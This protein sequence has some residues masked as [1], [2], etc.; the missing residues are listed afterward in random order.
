MNKMQKKGR[1]IRPGEVKSVSIEKQMEMVRQ[2]FEERFREKE[3]YDRQTADDRHLRLL[4]DM[5]VAADNH[6]IIDLGTGSGYLAFALARKYPDCTV[7]GLDTVTDTLRRNTQQARRCGLNNLK[8]IAGDGQRMPFADGSA[9][10]IIT[11][12]ALHHFADISGCFQEAHRVLKPGGRLIIADPEPNEDDRCGF[13]DRFMQ[14]KADGHVRFYRLE[15]YRRMLADAG[16][17]LV[18]FRRTQICFP[19]KEAKRYAA[20]LEEAEPDVIRGYQI[21][22][23][24]DEIWIT[25]N[26]LNMLL[27]KSF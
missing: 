16:F 9:D 5:T 15:E 18:F 8:F 19:R 20:L 23:E 27:I 14:M 13:A 17:K 1:M 21:R 10:L 6:R 11:R 7:A 12:Y 2:S 24:D 22:I 25:E 3:Y 4:L 26:V